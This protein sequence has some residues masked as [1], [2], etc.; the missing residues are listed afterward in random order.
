MCVCVCIFEGDT[1]SLEFNTFVVLNRIN[2]V[3]VESIISTM[4]L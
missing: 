2:S 1:R 4:V 3:A